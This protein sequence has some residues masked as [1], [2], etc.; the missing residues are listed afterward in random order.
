[1]LLAEITVVE[2]RYQAVMAVFQKGWEFRRARYS[3]GA[4]RTIHW[5]NARHGRYPLARDGKPREDGGNIWKPRVNNPVPASTVRWYTC[6]GS[7]MLC[8]TAGVLAV[9]TG[10]DSG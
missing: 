7:S 4:R 8:P 5:W 3:V 10:T 1:M 9:M 2:Q 6:E